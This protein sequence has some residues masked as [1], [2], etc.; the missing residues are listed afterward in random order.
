MEV[1]VNLSFVKGFQDEYKIFNKSPKDKSFGILLR[2]YR[3]GIFLVGYFSYVLSTAYFV[4]N[5]MIS[6][7]FEALS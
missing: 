6:Y 2:K 3:F 7:F 1:L 4:E 5:F